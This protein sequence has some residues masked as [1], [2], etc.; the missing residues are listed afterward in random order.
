MRF[1]QLRRVWGEFHEYAVE[2]NLTDSSFLAATARILIPAD[3]STPTDALVLLDA[4]QDI[5]D[6]LRRQTV[7]T[8][9]LH[10]LDHIRVYGD[11]AKRYAQNK[12]KE[13]EDEHN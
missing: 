11:I 3:N 8:N 12:I 9:G 2:N 1:N 7:E 6:E 4:I 10:L 13:M 5:Y